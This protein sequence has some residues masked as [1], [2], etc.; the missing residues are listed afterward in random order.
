MFSA[1]RYAYD[2]T[3][4]KN[5]EYNVSYGNNPTDTEPPYNIAQTAKKREVVL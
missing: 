4:E 3:K 5:T 1:K 2:C